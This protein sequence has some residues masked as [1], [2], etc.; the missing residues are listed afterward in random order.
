MSK[1]TRPQLGARDEAALATEGELSSVMAAEV[2]AKLG[3][4]EEAVS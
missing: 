4:T 2:I 1:P 3:D